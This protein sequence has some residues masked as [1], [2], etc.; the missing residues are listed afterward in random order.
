MNYNF[1]KHL[2]QIVKYNNDTYVENI[3]N[4]IESIDDISKHQQMY[5]NCNW[6]LDYYEL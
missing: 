4:I 6:I 2:Q 3:N 1:E 5:L